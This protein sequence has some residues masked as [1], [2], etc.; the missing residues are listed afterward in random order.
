M[1]THIF[2][3][4]HVTLNSSTPVIDRRFPMTRPLN[5]TS[6]SLPLYR[7]STF[8]KRC[9]S[10]STTPMSKKSNR[11]A[12]KCK[13]TF[14]IIL[15]ISGEKITEN[16]TSPRLT[17]CPVQLFHVLLHL[18]Q[19]QRIRCSFSLVDQL[20]RSVEVA[21]HVLLQLRLELN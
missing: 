16:L 2:S 19:Y 18:F 12:L 4:S 15:N 21:V 14:F 20:I 7:V 5:V 17:T 11:R 6:I 9:F 8:C 13:L 3:G 10:I 1:S